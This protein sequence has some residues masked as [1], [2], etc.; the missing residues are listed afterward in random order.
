MVLG[1]WK[2]NICYYGMKIFNNGYYYIGDIENYCANGEGKFYNPEDFLIYDGILKQ[3][4]FNS[5]GKL[6][7]QNNLSFYGEFLNNFI[8]GNGKLE[9]EKEFLYEGDF[10]NNKF[11][12]NGTLKFY[13]INEEFTGEFKDNKYNGRGIYVWNSGNYYEGSYLEGKKNGIGSLYMPNDIV[14]EC[15]WSNGKLNGK[16]IFKNEKKKINSIWRTG[17]LIYMDD[18]I[19]EDHKNGEEGKYKIPDEIEK[20]F[21]QFEIVYKFPDSDDCEIIN[22]E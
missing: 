6:N 12:G 9:K 1:F 11:N 18:L 2:K 14:F 22:I 16:G 17:N 19:L 3:D 10:I 21:E 4:K 8:C 7:L 20:V 15:Y 5:L 13:D